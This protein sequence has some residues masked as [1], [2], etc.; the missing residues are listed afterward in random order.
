MIVFQAGLLL[1][2]KGCWVKG[3]QYV[4]FS[5]SPYSVDTMV[6]PPVLMLSTVVGTTGALGWEVRGSELHLCH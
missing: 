4:G 6:P 5:F 3:H 2:T 1:Q